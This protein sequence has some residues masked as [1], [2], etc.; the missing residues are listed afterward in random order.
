MY[1]LRLRWEID[2]DGSWFYTIGE[3]KVDGFWCESAAIKAG[4]NHLKR[5]EQQKM[6]ELQAELKDVERSIHHILMGVQHIGEPVFM[7]DVALDVL[8]QRKA[9]ITELLE[10][11]ELSDNF[12]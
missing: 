8:L 10:Y 7:Q 12:D 11:P 5:L 6:D 4:L 9:E 3:V 2:A 1:G